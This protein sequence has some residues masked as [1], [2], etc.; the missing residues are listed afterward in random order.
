MAVRRGRTLLLL[1]ANQAK[2]A[3]LKN[4]NLTSK[5]LNTLKIVDFQCSRELSK[6][7]ALQ[8]FLFDWHAFVYQLIV[9]DQNPSPRL[10]MISN[11]SIDYVRQCRDE[12]RDPRGDSKA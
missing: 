9:K 2:K 10:E 1:V 12:Q 7:R 6:R 3:L 8:S 4:K 11:Q 5:N